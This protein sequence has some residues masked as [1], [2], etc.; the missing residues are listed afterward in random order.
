L[1]LVV[2]GDHENGHQLA[3]RHLAHQADKFNAIQVRHHVV[4]ND[5]VGH[6]FGDPGQCL[7]RVGKHPGLAVVHL[8][9]QRAKQDQVDLGVIDDKH[10]LLHGFSSLYLVR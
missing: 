7:A 9:H 3:P 8:F 2:G 5:Q 4:H 1:L 6:V 10:L